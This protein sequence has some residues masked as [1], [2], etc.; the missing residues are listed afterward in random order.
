MNLTKLSKKQRAVLR[1]VQRLERAIATEGSMERASVSRTLARLERR[2]LVLR[3]D[4]R[5]VSS[6]GGRARHSAEEPH[7]KTTH[8]LMTDARGALV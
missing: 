5:S 4:I 8:V 6:P 3:Q 2:G 1:W 7:Q